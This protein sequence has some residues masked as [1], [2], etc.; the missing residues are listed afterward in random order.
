[1]RTLIV[2]GSTQGQTHKIAEFVAE[3][4]RGQGHDVAVFDAARIAS[5]VRARLSR[6]GRTFSDSAALIRED[7]RR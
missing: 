1:M 4:W 2:Y 3:R 7:R 5:A 6:S